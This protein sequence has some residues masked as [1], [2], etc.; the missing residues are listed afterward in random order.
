MSPTTAAST[1]KL[2]SEGAWLV[3][4]TLVTL[5]VGLGAGV[6]GIAVDLALQLLQ[7]LAFGYSSGSLLEGVTQAP[8]WRRFAS[9]VAAGVVG[10]VGW[11][12][13]RRWGSHVVS[14]ER[15]AKGTPM[16]LKTTI[17]NAALQ[18]GIVGLGASIGREAAP[19]ELG[20]LF[21]DKVTRAAGL[22]ERE[23]K[24]LVACGAGAGLAA[25]YNV[26]F[27]GALFVVEILLAEV[28]FATLLPA[29][30]ASALAAAVARVVVPVSPMYALPHVAVTPQLVGWAVV[31]GPLIGLA[32]S[33]FVRVTRI[34]ASTKPRG[35]AI[36][37]AMPLIFAGV[38]AIS[39]FLPEVLGNGKAAAQTVF[40]GTAP[41]A[42]VTL[43][44]IAKTAT[45]VGTIKA[46]AAG[47]TLTPSVA[48]GAMLGIALGSVVNL[49]MPGTSTAA[50]AFVGAAAFLASTM[51]APM[52]GLILVTEFTGQGP[53]LLVP[54]MAA[55]A[56]AL[57]VVYFLERT[58]L[59]DIA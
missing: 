28:S 57:A 2:R 47:G 1:S 35:R 39:L 19:R 50:F 31:A 41:L 11:W 42:V 30:A 45:T 6:V 43:L 49:V 3:R 56:G 32:A 36:L 52:T 9:L 22:S 44:L 48:I 46:G 14:V 4:L 23:A 21:A 33:G 12:A 37:W 54:G 34:A 24:I 15:A 55:I 13:L 17:A 10:G 26:P 8:P 20:A 7:H 5:L 51:R 18:I 38:G 16:P 59:S 40:S 58:R 29:F 27:G 53:E 25:V